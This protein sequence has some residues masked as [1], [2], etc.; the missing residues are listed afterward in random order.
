MLPMLDGPGPYCYIA[1]QHP[2]AQGPSAAAAALHLP[3]SGALRTSQFLIK[4]TR[5]Y[6]VLRRERQWWWSHG[7]VVSNEPPLYHGKYPISG[8]SIRP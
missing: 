8:C 5:P 6:H 1:L 4:S 3:Y 7:V 2:L